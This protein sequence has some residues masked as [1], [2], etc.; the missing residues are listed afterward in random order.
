[1]ELIRPESEFNPEAPEIGFYDLPESVYRAAPGENWSTM[2]VIGKT[3]KKY[4]H[5]KDNPKKRTEA[6]KFGNMFHTVVLEPHLLAERYTTFPETYKGKPTGWKKGDDLVDKPWRG[7]ATACRVWVAEKV[8]NGVECFKKVEINYA[9]AM[10]RELHLLPDA[11]KLLDNADGYEVSCFWT[12]EKNGLPCKAKIDI[13]KGGQIGDLKKITASGGGA[14]WEAFSFTTRNLGYHGQAAFYRDGVTAVL[15]H[16]KQ[17][18]PKIPLFTWLVVEDEAPYDTAIYPIMDDP[19]AE[20]YEWFVKGRELY[21]LYLWQ[22]QLWRE[23]G[24]WPS[25][26]VGT[27]QMTEEHELTIPDRLNLE[28]IR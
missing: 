24:M 27:S 25:H 22:I 9:K 28:I 17:P 2:K 23:K 1:M 5:R 8:G 26:N 16:L 19:R 7:N 6:M 11:R 18:L 14:A 12:D 20:S 3:P 10:S 13:L 21:D 15:K 4:K